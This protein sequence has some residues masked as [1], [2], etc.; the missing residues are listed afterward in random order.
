MK[1]KDIKDVDTQRRAIVCKHR[2]SVS[3]DED[4]KRA[5]VW[6]LT[7]EGHEFWKSVNEGVICKNANTVLR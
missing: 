5:F 2:Q 6:R 4:L 7:W 1:I 3:S